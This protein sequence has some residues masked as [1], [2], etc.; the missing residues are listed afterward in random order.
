MAGPKAGRARVAGSSIVVPVHCPLGAD[1]YPN[2]DPEQS[3]DHPT[4]YGED[5]NH[6]GPALITAAMMAAS[7]AENPALQRL[8]ALPVLALT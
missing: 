5:H 7:G 8:V 3:Q 1:T 4:D 6:A 2:E